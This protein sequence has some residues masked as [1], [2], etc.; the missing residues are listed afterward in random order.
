MWRAADPS[1]PMGIPVLSDKL[2]RG[3]SHQ[4]MALIDALAGEWCASM[5][6]PAQLRAKSNMHEL[7]ETEQ[8]LKAIAQDISEKH[9]G[10]PVVIVMGGQNESSILRTMTATSGAEP[11][12]LR[13]LVG[14]LETAKQI[15]SWKHIKNW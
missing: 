14:I 6:S 7:H 8:E 2:T 1:R 5:R 13:D 9:G 10:A 11:M 15:E 4:R 3:K 12:R